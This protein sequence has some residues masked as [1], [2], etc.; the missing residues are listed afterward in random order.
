MCHG[1][2][3]EVAAPLHQQDHTAC[4]EPLKKRPAVASHRP[5]SSAGAPSAF[6]VTL[7]PAAQWRCHRWS[8][9]ASFAW[10]SA[11]SGPPS[12]LKIRCAVRQQRRARSGLP[13]ARWTWPSTCHTTPSPC[14]ADVP[15]HPHRPG[16]VVDGVVVAPQAQ[17]RLAQVD[18]GEAD[19]AQH[20]RL[21]EPVAQPPLELQRLSIVDD[22]LVEA[23]QVRQVAGQ[24]AEHPRQGSLK[25]KLLGRAI[26]VVLARTGATLGL[27]TAANAAPTGGTAAPASANRAAAVGPYSLQ[28]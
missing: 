26:A 22:G 23:V 2:K 16:E 20:R 11:T 14:V 18:E 19:V 21:A 12:S 9:A 25:A 3:V 1:D 17:V 6:G 24:P 4:R 28:P 15:A 13:V 10:I 5:S 27:A 7:S 8:M